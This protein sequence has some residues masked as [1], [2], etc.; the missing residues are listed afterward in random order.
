MCTFRSLQVPLDI[1]PNHHHFNCIASFLTIHETN[2]TCETLS[3][4]KT[5]YISI[6]CRKIFAGHARFC[7]SFGWSNPFGYSFGYPEIDY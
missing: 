1:P 7:N 6:F 5:Y 2:L 3:F 4:P